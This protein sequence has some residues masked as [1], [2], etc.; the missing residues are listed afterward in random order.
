[1]CW[2]ISLNSGRWHSLLFTLALKVF[3]ITGPLNGRECYHAKY[4]TSFKGRP[5]TLN[6]IFP[7]ITFFYLIFTKL[8]L[9]SVYQGLLCV[10]QSTS[11]QQRDA[12]CIELKSL[13]YF[14]NE[15]I[16]L[17]WPVDS[18]LGHPLL[19]QCPLAAQVCGSKELGKK[20]HTQKKLQLDK[21][22]HS[23]HLAL[24]NK[25]HLWAVSS[26]KGG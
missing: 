3:R 25:A 5:C 21:N 16:K 1:M 4:L 18:V 10:H 23:K 11:H 14:S 9:T 17:N 7:H 26:T 15:K 8:W 6:M 24:N 2:T 12:L 19:K 22:T 13:N 20:T